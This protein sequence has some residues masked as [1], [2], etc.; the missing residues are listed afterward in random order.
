M[1]NDQNL[2]SSD[3]IKLQGLAIDMGV[4]FDG[5]QFTYRQ[6]KYDRLN[7][8]LRY[9]AADIVRSGKDLNTPQSSIIWKKKKSPEI[10]DIIL[11]N[12][13]KI[14]F[15]NGFYEY[16]GYKYENLIDAVN[17]ASKNVGGE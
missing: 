8:A 6:Y 9:A 7:D 5:S 2:F 16:M 11:M 12:R 10:E 15:K 13:H 1:K 3:P 17:Y 14:N 4:G